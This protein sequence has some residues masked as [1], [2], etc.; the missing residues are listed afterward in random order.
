MWT[1]EQQDFQLTQVLSGLQGTQVFISYGQQSNDSLLQYYGFVE[2]G[3]PHDT[4]VLPDLAAAVGPALAAA[5][6]PSLKVQLTKMQ[7]STENS[8]GRIMAAW[9]LASRTHVCVYSRKAAVA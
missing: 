1:I 9:S 6:L 8:C 3:N 4:Y 2:P 5:K 7:H